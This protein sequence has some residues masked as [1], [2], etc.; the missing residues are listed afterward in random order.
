[1]RAASSPSTEF[2]D[3]TSAT[4]LVV[5]VDGVLVHEWYADGVTSEDRL[6]G[7]SATKSALALVT[8]V[9]V[10]AGRLADLDA[11]IRDLVPELAASG[12]RRGDGAP[13]C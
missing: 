9:A 4:S 7:N 10:S 6:L 12:Y 3:V 5:V 2:L 8:G 11:P 1:M 13:A